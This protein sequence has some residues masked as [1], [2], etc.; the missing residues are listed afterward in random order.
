MVNKKASTI[1]TYPHDK[2]IM[3]MK[4]LDNTSDAIG[5]C[6]AGEHRIYQNKAF[7][8]LFEFET[9]DELQAAEGSSAII[10]CEKSKSEMSAI[11]KSGVSWIGELRMLTKRGRIFPAFGRIDAIKDEN[12]KIIGFIEVFTD[13]TKC[14]QVEKELKTQNSKYSTLLQNLNGMV[15]H[16]RHNKKWTMEFISNGCSELTGYKPE[17]LLEDS[18]LSFK[19]IILPKYHEYLSVKWETKL[20]NHDTFE[21]EYEIKTASGKIKWVLERGCGI[22]NKNKQLLHIEGY[23]FDITKRKKAEQRL[24]ESKY[25]YMKL[26]DNAQIGLFRTRFADGLFLEANL[27]LV[28]MFGYD[29]RDELIEKVSIQDYYADK[30]I[31]SDI[32]PKLKEEGQLKNYETRF[33]KKDGSIWWAHFS[34]N[35]DKEEGYIEGVCTDITKN[36]EAEAENKRLEERHLQ[37]Q[38]VEAIGRLAAGVAHDL[39]NLLTPILGYGEILMN[40]FSHDD[41]RKRHVNQIVQAGYRIRSLVRQLLAFGRKQTLEYRPLNLNNIIKE[42]EK[43]MR[44]T[45]REDIEF[46]IIMADDIETFKADIGQVEQVLMNLSVNAQDAMPEGGKLTIET[47]MIEMGE[48]D[49]LMHPG[50]QAGRYVSLIISDTGCG[51]DKETRELIFEPFFSTKGEQGTGL[52]LATVYGIVKQHRGNIWVYSEPGEGTSFK[53]YL[54]VSDEKYLEKK[55]PKESGKDLNGFE[56]ILLVE[57]NEQVR[58]ICYTILK[59]NKYRVLIA[60]N[61]AEALEILESH[62]ESVHLLLSDVIMPGMNGKEL[63]IKATAKQPGIKVLY[64][65]GYTDNIIAQHGVLDEGVQFIQKPFT[66]HGLATKIREVLEQTSPIL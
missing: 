14:K 24:Q 36:K 59:Q 46:E 4:A 6:D 41:T 17:E 31:R 62:K 66:F 29:S 49:V 20:K 52:G 58:D 44:R 21:E 47:A 48:E 10:L 19:D 37:T 39:N 43:L 18:C 2:L 27:Q 5:I 35:F 63:F 30:N 1:N 32:I 54:P 56:T 45:I 3:I 26:F 12:G 65:S 64:M 34:A 8:D 33:K 11:I 50:T 15:Y 7:C 61:G 22:F 57:D 40:N 13:W 60:K 38:K 9:A 55:A 28:K 53:V 16:C 51:M 42:F 23:I 25:K